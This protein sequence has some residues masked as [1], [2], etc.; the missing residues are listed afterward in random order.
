MK[1]NFI[2]TPEI[3][4][5]SSL[6]HY[7]PKLLICCLLSTY[8]NLSQVLF[9]GSLS[10]LL[11]RDAGNEFFRQTITYLLYKKARNFLNNQV[12]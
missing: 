11:M 2:S 12:L 7:F 6:S 8:Q 1:L 5:K 4:L 9:H 3:K 10:Y